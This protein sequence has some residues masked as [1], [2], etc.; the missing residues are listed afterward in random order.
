MSFFHAAD[1]NGET[2]YTRKTRS[3]IDTKEEPVSPKMARIFFWGIAVLPAA[4]ILADISRYVQFGSGLGMIHL[5]KNISLTG[6][7]SWSILSVFLILFSAVSIRQVRKDEA[8]RNRELSSGTSEQD[9]ELREKALERGKNRELPY[10]R[11]IRT[12]VIGLAVLLL[13]FLVFHVLL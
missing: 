4:M 7:V 1:Q 2:A 11:N 5:M 10:V 6:L 8:E 9:R 12:A 13:L 3:I